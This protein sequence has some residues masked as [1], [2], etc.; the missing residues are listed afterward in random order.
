M[1][2]RDIRTSH[3]TS[4]CDVCGRTLLRGEHADVYL[5]GGTRR[6]V[7]ELCKTRALH[8]GWVR[9]GTV[10]A[11]E[12]GDS[13]SDRRRSLLGRLRGRPREA[14]NGSSAAPTLDDELDGQSWSESGTGGIEL[15]PTSPGGRPQPPPARRPRESTRGGRW[16]SRT[17]AG[18]PYR[19]TP[20][21]PGREPRHVHA[22]P[23]SAEQ[24]IVA[25]IEVFNRSEYRRTV[26]GVARSLGEPWVCITP[27]ENRPGL[28]NLVVSWEL[29]WYRYDVDLSEDEPTIRVSGQGY[30]LEEL[31]PAERIANAVADEHGQLALGH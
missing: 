29:C 20:R 6:C 23:A 21:G 18:D 27:V 30:E 1:T 5:N 4:V 13:G 9:E 8:E 25:A 15:S 14:E 17:P 26:S 24:K 19:E 28:V 16:G 7:C 12:T 10:P 31:E 2:T 22:V 11:Y 3:E